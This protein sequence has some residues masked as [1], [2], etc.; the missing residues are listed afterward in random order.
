ME[1]QKRITNDVLLITSEFPPGPGGIGSHAFS[2]ANSLSHKGIVM[3]VAA[4]TNYVSANQAAE[5]DAKEGG[6]LKI[7]RF[8][9]VGRFYTF[10]RLL[11]LQRLIRQHDYDAVILSGMFSLWAGMILKW[12]FPRLKTLAVLHGSEVN[13]GSSFY[14]KITHRA[15]S[16]ADIILPVSRFTY[17]LLPRHLQSHAFQIIPNGI[18]PHKMPVAASPPLEMIVGE[19]ALLTVGNVTLR[20][21]QQRVIRALPELVKYYPKL[22]YNVVGLPTLADD[23]KALA[24]ELGVEE[25]VHFH[26]RLQNRNDLGRAY[27]SSDVFVILSEN[28][29]DGNVEGFGIVVLEANFYGIP[30]IGAL[31]CGIEA[32]IEDGFNGCLVDG[33]NAQ[34][35]R[36]ALDRIIAD[37]QGYSTRA[38][39]WASRHDWSN[40]SSS[41]ESI[42]NKISEK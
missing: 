23:F 12:F 30:V 9:N 18:E 2:L 35:I 42:I 38:R 31:G 17:G 22:K 29:P 16:K 5:F 21:G 19:P 37:Y 4:V 40:I 25:V 27:S 34:E 39:E 15:I 7:T 14:R 13:V 41:F 8:Y 3:H 26:G 11:T 36:I 28:Q 6:E 32:A 20:K 33:N 10:N 1:R 24:H